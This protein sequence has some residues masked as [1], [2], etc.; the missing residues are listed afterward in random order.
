MAAGTPSQ[1]RTPPKPSESA[2]SAT[3]WK[4]G[5]ESIFVAGA[6]FE[7]IPSQI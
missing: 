4:P 3:H 6:I 7:R 1:V 5:G 2:M